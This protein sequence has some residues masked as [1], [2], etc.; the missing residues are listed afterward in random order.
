M[1][2][3]LGGFVG[4]DRF[5]HLGWMKLPTQPLWNF[6]APC[7]VHDGQHFLSLRLREL[8]CFWPLFSDGALHDRVDPSK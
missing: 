5:G 8:D 6:E 7:S 4:L 3:G 2:G 1:I